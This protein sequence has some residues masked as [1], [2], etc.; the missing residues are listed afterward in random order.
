MYDAY[1]TLE[2]YRSIMFS[3]HMSCIIYHDVDKVSLSILHLF[4][5][6][7]TSFSCYEQVCVL[8][9][10]SDLLLAGFSFMPDKR[11]FV[12]RGM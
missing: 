8:Q 12:K 7:E 3:G 10:Q 11:I 2:K 6:I 4:L 1:I 9:Y 5:L